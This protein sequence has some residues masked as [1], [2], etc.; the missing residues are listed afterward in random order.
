VKKAKGKPPSTLTGQ[1]PVS[2]DDSPWWREM[3][4][5]VSKQGE[6]VG[7]TWTIEEITQMI[8]DYPDGRR[9]RPRTV[10]RRLLELGTIE[11]IERGPNGS[12]GKCA[13]YRILPELPP[14]PAAGPVVENE[15]YLAKAVERMTKTKG[16]R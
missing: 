12:L 1:L 2:A 11:L 14:A 7:T 10:S 4:S 13:K 9:P 15:D 16:K 8:P 3:A 5:T 6:R